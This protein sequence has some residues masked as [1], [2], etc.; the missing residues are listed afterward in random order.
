VP[1]HT[2]GDPFADAAEAADILATLT[3]VEGHDVAVILGTG[4]FEAAGCLGTTNEQVPFARLPGFAEEVPGGQLPEVWSTSF[5]G[6]NLL[7]FLGRSHL[8]QGFSPCEVAHPVRTA[9]ASGCS[10][11]VITNASGSLDENLTPGDLVL[12]RDHLNLTASSPLTGL[13]KGQGGRTPFVDLT[14]AWSPRLRQIARQ[15]D[16]SLSEG[17]YAQLPGPNF[18]TPAEIRMLR[19]L[20]ADLVGMSSVIEAI[21]ARHL[22]ADVL[23]I[24]VVTNPAAGLAPGA[25]SAISLVE[26]ARTRAEPLGSLVREVVSRLA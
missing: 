10:T 12:V 22:G 18:E 3:G 8:Y 4:L 5:A 26:L 19:A 24:S 20:G 1:A 6:H 14:D 23:G 17:V 25:V 21:A 9:M 2:Q 7:V 15:V 13:A 16:G 11:V